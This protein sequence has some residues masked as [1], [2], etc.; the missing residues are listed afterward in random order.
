MLGAFDVWADGVAVLDAAGHIV[1]VNGSWERFARDN[2]GGPIGAGADYLAACDAAGDD[3]DIATI[4]AG[5]RAVLAGTLSVYRH[6]YPCRGP[7]T[8]RWYEVTAQPLA[9]D[10]STGLLVNHTDITHRRA[11]S[12]EAHTRA[13]LLDGV[14]SEMRLRTIT[15]SIGDG[16]CTLDPT[17]HI[18]YVNPPGRRMLRASLTEP[19]GGSFLR[20]VHGVGGAGPFA[21]SLTDAGNGNTGP[22]AG[23]LVRRDGSELSIEYVATPLCA[24]ATAPAAG[25]VVVFRDVSFRRAAEE[26]LADGVAEVECLQAI[27]GALARD[28][29]VLYAQPIVEL[30]SGRTVQHEL[31]L[32]MRDPAVPGGVITPD[33]FLPTAEKLGVA[34]ALDRWVLARGIE[35]AGRGHAVE[36]NLSAVSIEDA[37]LP[38]VIEQLLESS[39]ADPSDV[40]FEITETALLENDVTAR[41]FADRIRELGCQLALD[42]FGTGYG[43]F[44]YLKRFPLDL[45]KIDI[46]FVRDAVHDASSRAVIEAVVTLARA[47][48]LQTV[49]EGVEDEA[50]LALLGELGVDLAQGYLLGRPAPIDTVFPASEEA[51]P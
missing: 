27:R 20:W 36:I 41:Y 51:H 25:Y 32:R 35:L 30:S 19:I 38:H 49:A 9:L 14:A 34:S 12:D 40:V 13:R 6:E 5:L 4:G 39:G 29:L 22:V 7:G 23:Q 44:T 24:D 16:L 17:G 18:T 47:F 43:G 37:T 33:H 26:R 2:D 1:V 50:T 28:G 15:D 31:L 45:L 10:G 11:A 42:D 3:P 48:D 8:E 46:E 21:D